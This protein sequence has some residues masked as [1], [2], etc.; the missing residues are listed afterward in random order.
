MGDSIKT[1]A[2][3]YTHTAYL[4]IRTAMRK[5]KIAGYWKDGGRLRINNENS[6]PFAFI[7]MLPRGGWD[8]RI[9]F[10]KIG[11]PAPGSTHPVP[12]RPGSDAD[13]DTDEA[14]G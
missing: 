13:E 5:G 1:D 10:V 8:G 2:A 7:D 14:D 6:E 12:Q 3:G 11:D 4:F 9:R